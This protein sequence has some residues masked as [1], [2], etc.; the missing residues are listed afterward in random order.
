[1]HKPTRALSCPH[2]EFIIPSWPVQASVKA[3]C[4]TRC[5]GA[6]LPPYDD[7]NLALHVGDDPENVTSNRRCLQQQGDLPCA[8]YWLNQQHTV[9]VVN[10][11]SFDQ[12]DWQAPIADAAWSRQT[13]QVAVVMTADCLPILITNRSAT[14]VA[15]IHAG[16]RG[17][18][19]GIVSR[20]VKQLPESPEALLV[21]IGPHIRQPYFEVGQ[22]VYDAFAELNTHNT[23][24]FTAIKDSEGKYLADLAGLLKL[25]L[26]GL[27][28]E[29]IYDSELCTYADESRFYSYRRDGQTG[30]IASL[31]WLAQ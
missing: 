1:M 18:A 2:S 17:L 15:A 25:E 29:Q 20:T 22:D 9:E 4:T 23:A 27:G 14:L 13:N 16:W 21:W 3:L 26:A 6:C 24:C 28:V 19:E 7:F 8:P 10:L 30:R 11:D 5:G 12:Q 31:I